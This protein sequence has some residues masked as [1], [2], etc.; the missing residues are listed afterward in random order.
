M[1]KITTYSDAGGVLIGNSTF[2]YLCNN[3]LGDCSV[4]VLILEKGEKAP[5]TANWQGMI[6]G[7]DIKIYECDC[8]SKGNYTEIPAG[9]YQL[10]SKCGTVWLEYVDD[11][12]L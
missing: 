6:S 9:R 10:Y 3:G 11:D 2:Q 1:R 5:R 12:L 7:S 4:K 8:M